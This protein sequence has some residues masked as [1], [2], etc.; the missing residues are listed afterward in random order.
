[1]AGST[2]KPMPQTVEGYKELAQRDLVLIEAQRDE[3]GRLKAKINQLSQ[4]RA[5]KKDAVRYHYMFDTGEFDYHQDWICESKEYVDAA[6]D[7]LIKDSKQ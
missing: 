4:G 6:I 1:M 5:R 7:E 3:I 2:N